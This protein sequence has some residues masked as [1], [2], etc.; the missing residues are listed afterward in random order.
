MLSSSDKLRAINLSSRNVAFGVFIGLFL[1]GKSAPVNAEFML[2]A[3]SVSARQL[4]ASDL[5]WTHFGGD[6]VLSRSD[7]FECSTNLVTHS[8]ADK[9]AT[10][11]QFVSERFFAAVRIL[12]ACDGTGASTGATGTGAMSSPAPATLLET[13]RLISPGIV[14]RVYAN[15]L[16]AVPPAP[17]FELRRPPKIATRFA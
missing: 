15:S 10:V 16:R 9:A 7:A 11:E 14:G 8:P 5:S 4:A 3:Q 1:A 6:F 12:D 2:V 17:P 13:P